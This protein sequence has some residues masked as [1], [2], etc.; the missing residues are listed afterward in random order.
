VANSGAPESLSDN[1]INQETAQEAMD[2]NQ[3]T[4]SASNALKIEDT[5]ESPAQDKPDNCLTEAV[6]K[7][8]GRFNFKQIGKERTEEVDVYVRGRG[9]GRY[10]CEQ[11]GIKCKKPS[12]LKKHLNVHTDVR[13]FKCECF[14]LSKICLL[15][16]IFRHN[17]QFCV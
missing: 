2:I 9:R 1:E 5:Q 6:T 8:P 10:V 14:R 15:H 12:M 11:C 7:R 13:M 16:K 4:E 3:S 17:M